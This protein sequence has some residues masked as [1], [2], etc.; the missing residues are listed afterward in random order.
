VLDPKDDETYALVVAVA[1]GDV[2]HL[3]VIARRLAGWIT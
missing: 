1:A 2:D 3:T